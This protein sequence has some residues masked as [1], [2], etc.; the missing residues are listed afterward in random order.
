MA[1]N[2]PPVNHPSGSVNRSSSTNERTDGHRVKRKIKILEP[3][4]RFLWLFFF[5][6]A[7]MLQNRTF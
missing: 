6:H 4:M 2:R 1:V 7:L 5:F 3:E